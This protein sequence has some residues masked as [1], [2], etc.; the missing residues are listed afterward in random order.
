MVAPTTVVAAADEVVSLSV[1][2]GVVKSALEVVLAITI[3][4]ELSVV[5]KLHIMQC[6][7]MHI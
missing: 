5:M 3:K 4:F 6:L 2:G 1:V 7:S